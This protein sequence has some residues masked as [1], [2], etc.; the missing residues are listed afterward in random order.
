[1]NEK[2]FWTTEEEDRLQELSANHTLAEIGVIMGMTRSKVAGKAMRMKIEFRRKNTIMG[3]RSYE[4]RE[5][6]L[7][8]R[9]WR[10]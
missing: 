7:P 6:E 9:D 10:P 5:V 2:Q 8:P 3:P 1:M 4:A